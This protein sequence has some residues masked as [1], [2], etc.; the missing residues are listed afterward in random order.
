MSLKKQLERYKKHLNTPEKTSAEKSPHAPNDRLTRAVKE[1]AHALGAELR[2]LDEQMILVRKTRVPLTALH[3]RRPLKDIFQA[4]SLW[5]TG[6]IRHPLSAKGLN[7]Q[8]LLFFDTETTGL[9]SGAGHMIFLLGCG[10]IQ[11]DELIITQYFLPGPG[12]EAAFYYHFLSDVKDLSN[13]VTFNGKAFDWPRVKTRVAFVRDAVPHL[14]AFGH[15]DLLHA[16]RRLWKN[17]WD[18][19]R[20]SVVEENILGF[21]RQNDIPGHMAPFLYFEFLKSPKASLVEG[22]F[23]HNADD[24]KTLLS[25]YSHLTHLIHFHNI[26][27]HDDEIFALARWSYALG[28]YATALDML[29]QVEAITLTPDT[30]R[31]VRLRADCLKKVGKLKEALEIY[32]TLADQPWVEDPAVLIECAKLYEHFSKDFE[33]ALYYA[34][35]AQQLLLK[36]TGM[37]PE[38][39]HKVK[40]DIQKRLNRL[41]E[42]INVS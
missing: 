28:E 38:R 12:H 32:K 8:D 35:K 41:R 36:K 16:S 42:K 25:L 2:T 20:L 40:L 10:A 4:V 11:G 31:F 5:Q 7:A 27:P 22:I 23:R 6:Q 26:D 19:V 29:D 13:L 1:A 30:A 34:E 18:S 3:G 15:F 39:L 21:H 37:S 33:Q 17:Q 9:S 14:P 24:I